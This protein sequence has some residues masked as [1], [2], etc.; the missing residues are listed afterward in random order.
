MYRPSLLIQTLAAASIVVL[1][2][3]CVGSTMTNARSVGPGKVLSSQKPAQRVAECVEFAWQNEAMFGIDAN[4]YLNN[5][6]DGSFTVYTREAAYFA[7]VKPQGSGASLA[8]YAPAVSS[9]V[10]DQ[11]LAALATCL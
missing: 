7:D 8:F 5:P 11:R 1:L 9:A 3:G 6:K 4:A 10:S 2:G